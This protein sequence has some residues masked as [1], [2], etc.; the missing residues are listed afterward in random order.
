MKITR[1]LL[2]PFAS[3]LLLMTAAQAQAV[4][5][6]ADVG[7]SVGAATQVVSDTALSA[8]IKTKLAT[9]SRLKASNISVTTTDH[10]AVLTGTAPSAEAKK[11]AEDLALHV[12]GVTRVDN[13]I[14]APSAM[15]S[16]GAE[17]KAGAASTGEKITDG[18]I[19]TKIKTQL[20]ADELTK[21]SAIKVSTKNNVVY[22]RGK[23]GSAEEK[24]KAI[25]LASDIEGVKSVNASK[26]IVSADVKA[27]AAVN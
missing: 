11:A 18:W 15:A 20:L 26:L 9:D 27:G 3:A 14:E 4:S 16:L 8:T 12:E 25:Q 22:L 13:R 23:A 1:N 6:S 17:V 7:V 21:A 19:S 5:L 10:V 24:A 2:T